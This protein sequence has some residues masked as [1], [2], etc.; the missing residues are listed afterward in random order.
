MRLIFSHP[1][2]TLPISF[3][4]LTYTITE[5]KTVYIAQLCDSLS[6]GGKIVTN[7]GIF[8]SIKSMWYRINTFFVICVST[9]KHTTVITKTA[10]CAQLC[11]YWSRVAKLQQ[12][13]A[14]SCQNSLVE[15]TLTTLPRHPVVRWALHLHLAPVAHI[16]II[17]LRLA[18]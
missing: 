18:K 3:F 10:F 14:G 16:S 12:N 17:L 2:F 5:T 13:R 7:L 8:L 15:T 11:G 9:L 1:Q 6:P 4:T